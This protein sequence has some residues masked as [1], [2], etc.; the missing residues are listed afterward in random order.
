[1]PFLLSQLDDDVEQ[2]IQLTDDVIV[3]GRHPDCSVVIDDP[4]VSRRH[5]QIVE[6]KGKFLLED[7]KS[8]NG[9]YL[10]RRMI[11]QSTRLL[12]GDQIRICDA[13]FTFFL[14]E[15][16]HGAAAPRRTQESRPSSLESSILL[17]D[18]SGSG[19]LSSIMSQMDLSSHHKEMVASPE[20]KL[21]AL[22]EITKS[23]GRTIALDKVLPKVLDCLFDLFK[24]ADRGFI[25]MADGDGNLK[26]LA[27]KL[28]RENDEVT[29]RVSRTIVR[30]VLE[31]RQAIISTDAATDERFDLSQSIT[32]FRIRSM[33]CA[34]LFDTEGNSIGV[35][36]LD[37]LS[38]S[39]SFQN[40]DMDILATV[41]LQASSAIDKAKLYQIELRQQE[42]GRDLELANEIQHRLLPNEAPDFVG[43][44]LFDYYRPA[45]QVGGDYYDYIPLGNDRLAILVGDVVGHGIAAALLMAK[46]SAE[47]RFALASNQ[48]A[49]QAMSQLNQAISK[50]GLDRFI[51]IVLALLDRGTNKLTVVNA[52]HL[53]P[54]VGCKNGEAAALSTDQSGLPVG[55]MPDYDYE[56]FSVDLKPGDMVVLY[57]DG[58]NEAQNLQGELFGHQRVIDQ[59]KEKEWLS[60]T[61][62]GNSLIAGVRQHLNGN[63]QDDDVCLVCF[64]R[65]RE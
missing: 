40:E 48:T 26:P 54:I 28:R 41:A 24:Q 9:T 44:E 43:Y 58:V 49:A 31:K 33:M 14:D 65:E 12:S 15:S 36:Q 56:E 13:L 62:F 47:A 2:R 23:L 55:I 39:V 8:R 7:L 1:M 10:N 21:N 52:G 64:R 45:E 30:H 22:I 38:N 27:M 37:S 11:Q 3:I 63:Q 34:P 46:V 29:I 6:K 35:I 5:A 20:A 25:V 4:S 51:T 59:L 18:M 53:P 17:D 16:V 61:D 32:D 60:S 57:T 50:L 42:L 19:D